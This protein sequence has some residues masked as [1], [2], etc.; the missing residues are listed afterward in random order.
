M[1]KYAG[2]VAR[3]TEAHENSYSLDIDGGAWIWQDWMFDPDFKAGGP[4]SAE[5]AIWAML[6][7]ETLYSE[8]GSTKFYWD[9]G[10]FRVEDD[11]G[12]DFTGTFND[13]TFYRCPAKHKRT[14]TR[15]EVLDWA[16]SDASRGWVARVGGE[17]TW[18]TPQFFGYNMDVDKYERARLLPD[19]SGVDEDTIQGFEVEAEECRAGKLKNR[20]RTFCPFSRGSGVST[21]RRVGRGCGSTAIIFR[22]WTNTR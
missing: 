11:G 20:R 5:D 12:L 8:D 16:N 15:W 6:D 3:I 14:M 17:D 2:E 18:H 9:G 10:H 22:R 7:G 19:L 13:S 21:W 4:L 1:Q